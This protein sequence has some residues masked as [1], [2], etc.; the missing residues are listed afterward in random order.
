MEFSIVPVDE[1][2]CEGMPEKL[3][4]EVEAMK[5]MDAVTYEIGVKILGKIRSARAFVEETFKP[6]KRALA[7]AQ[8]ALLNAER[9]F[10]GPLTELEGQANGSLGAYKLEAARKAEEAA[11][12][13]REEAAAEAEHQRQAQI[14]ALA[15]AGRV[16]EA[17]ALA[18]HPPEPAEMF[19]AP[20]PE[21]PAVP[22]VEGAHDRTTW[23][24]A[25]TNLHELVKYV[26]AHPEHIV[27]VKADAKE[28]NKL[29]RSMRERWNIPGVRTWSEVSIVTRR[30]IDDTGERIDRAILGGDPGET[31]S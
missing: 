3:R 30:G 11:R 20:V 28:L 13:A 6:A 7:A 12:K 16:E 27:L 25:V 2:K 26:A 21:E 23:K 17:E 5:V 24:S 1:K 4:L 31:K 14:E 29:A 22:K 18:E 9:R 19:E 15:S 8:E 10:T